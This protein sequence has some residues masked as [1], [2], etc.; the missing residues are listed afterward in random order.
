MADADTVTLSRVEY[1][2]L[3]ERIEDLEDAAILAERRSDPT[4]DFETTKRLIAG[5]NPVKVWREERGLNQ[6]QLAAAADI[7]ASMLNEV[8]HGK[9]TPSLDMGRRIAKALN[10]DLDD[11]FGEP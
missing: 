2:A 7:S 5:E 11:L 8:E 4:I 1:E 9:R 6:R 10:V 3:L